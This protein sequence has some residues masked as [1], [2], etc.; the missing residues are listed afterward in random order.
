MVVTSDWEKIK[1]ELPEEGVELRFEVNYD[2]DWIEFYLGDYTIG[3][4]ICPSC[5]EY[6]FVTYDEKFVYE[7]NSIDMQFGL[8]GIIAKD[9]TECSISL[10]DESYDE[11]HMCFNL[12]GKE[13]CFGNEHNGYYS[14][15]LMIDKNDERIFV[16]SL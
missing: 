16:T 14:H 4:D 5:C 8:K 3:F 7:S 1:I 13:L 12:N 15:A 11:M 9:I 10:K 2:N 6:F